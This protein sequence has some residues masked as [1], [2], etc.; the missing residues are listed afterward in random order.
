MN[1]AISRRARTGQQALLRGGI[2]NLASYI[3]NLREKIGSELLLVPAVA[4]VIRDSENRI[5]LQEKPSGEGWSLPAGAIEPGES[6]Q[7]ALAR[8][9]IE[10]TGLIAS[11]TELLGVFGGRE[12]RYTYQNGDQVEHMVALYDCAVTGRGI[13]SREPETKALSFFSRT[14]MPPLALPY[15]LDFLFGHLAT[16]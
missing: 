12:Y 6:P 14:E 3:E 11:P 9:V 10:E 15:P 5:L 16:D 1:Q 2:S 7:E 13:E 8:E 4:A